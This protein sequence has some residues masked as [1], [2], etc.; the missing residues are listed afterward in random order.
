MK[1]FQVNLAKVVAII[2]WASIGII[3]VLSIPQKHTASDGRDYLIETEYQVK[4]RLPNVIIQEFYSQFES[5]SSTIGS[6]H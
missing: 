6:R 2:F 3:E 4:Q 1:A 5:T